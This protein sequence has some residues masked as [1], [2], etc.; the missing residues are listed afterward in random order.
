MAGPESSLCSPVLTL[1]LAE[2]LA[3][4]LLRNE[5]LYSRINVRDQGKIIQ[6]LIE[7]SV[8]KKIN[9]LSIV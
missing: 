4:R 8:F 3:E 6:P 7:N 9:Q 1:I 2:V 5:N